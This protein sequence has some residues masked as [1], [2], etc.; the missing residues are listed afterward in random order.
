MFASAAHELMFPNL[1]SLIIWSGIAVRFPTGLQGVIG[2]YP[3]PVDQGR[4]LM[5]C[6]VTPS[7]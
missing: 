7:S 6:Q 1:G 5:I 4:Q 2:H 3:R